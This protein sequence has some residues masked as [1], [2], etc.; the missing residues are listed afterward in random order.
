MQKQKETIYN[1]ISYT[2]K[3][4]KTKKVHSVY[5]RQFQIVPSGGF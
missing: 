2:E 1:L 4:M 3:N 5:N